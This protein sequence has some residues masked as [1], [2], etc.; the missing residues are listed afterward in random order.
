MSRPELKGH[1]NVWQSADH[2]K[3]F[4]HVAL[5]VNFPGRQ[6]LAYDFM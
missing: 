6:E 1:L 3:H 4:R 5:C 2:C